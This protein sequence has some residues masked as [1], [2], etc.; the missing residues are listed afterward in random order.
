MTNCWCGVKDEYKRD[1]YY[2]DNVAAE[3]PLGIEYGAKY[4]EFWIGDFLVA[5]GSINSGKEDRVMY[6]QQYV[7][8]PTPP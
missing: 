6:L 4:D 2:G 8:F 3:M 5:K 1:Y 7:Q